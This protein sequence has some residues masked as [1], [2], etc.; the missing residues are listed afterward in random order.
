MAYFTRPPSQ[1]TIVCAACLHA[2]ALLIEVLLPRLAAG[3]RQASRAIAS[4]RNLQLHLGL[5]SL[6]AELLFLLAEA[7]ALQL[8][9]QVA[10]T[11]PQRKQ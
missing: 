3:S 1:I 9:L 8:I 7:K 4:R 2:R 11:S 10:P 5:A 6:P